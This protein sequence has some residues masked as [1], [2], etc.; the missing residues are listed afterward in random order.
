MTS[1]EF[2]RCLLSPGYNRLIFLAA[3]ALSS[4]LER[5]VIRQRSRRALRRNAACLSPLTPCFMSA[6]AHDA[7]NVVQN[8]NVVVAVLTT[9]PFP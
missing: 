2:R 5:R 3:A 7:R 4:S 8:V 6:Q 9:P 1:V